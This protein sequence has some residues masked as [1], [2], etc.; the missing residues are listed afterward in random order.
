[1]SEQTEN[2]STSQDEALPPHPLE[3]GLDVYP[4]RDRAEDPRWAVRTVWIWVCLAVFL[5]VS[6]VVFLV[7]GLIYD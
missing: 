6:I 2:I 3:E 5:L 4:L 7:L 1:M